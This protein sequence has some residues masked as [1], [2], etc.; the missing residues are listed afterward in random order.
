MEKRSQK[1]GREEEATKATAIRSEVEMIRTDARIKQNS[2][3]VLSENLFE[4]K[5][6]VLW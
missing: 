3:K 4:S 6:I 2:S 1:A 5:K